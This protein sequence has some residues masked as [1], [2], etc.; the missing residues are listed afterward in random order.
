MVDYWQV[1]ITAG[2]NGFV[3]SLV[4]WVNNKTI[5]KQLEKI[6]RRYKNGKTTRK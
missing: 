1:I 3:V 5:I 2:L 4:Q 6:V